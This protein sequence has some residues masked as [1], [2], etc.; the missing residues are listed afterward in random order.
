MHGFGV[1]GCAVVD[2][3]GHVAGS[4]VRSM[5]HGLLLRM[6][7]CYDN[8]CM[9]LPYV[10]LSKQHIALQQLSWCQNLLLRPCLLPYHWPHLCL[11]C[12]LCTMSVPGHCTWGAVV[13]SG[14]PGLLSRLGGFVRGCIE[15]TRA[16]QQPN[17]FGSKF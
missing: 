3:L 5:C 16:V 6:R 12:C 15:Y 14:S 10:Q 11:C 2:H 9:R 7:L 8:A 1:V 17:C 4:G 13:V